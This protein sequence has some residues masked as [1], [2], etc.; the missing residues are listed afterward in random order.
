MNRR[1]VY[2]T[3]FIGSNPAR[4]PYTPKATP[5][6]RPWMLTQC[7]SY[8]CYLPLPILK[9]GGGREDTTRPRDEPSRFAAK[10][11]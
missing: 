4:G 3:P 1:S 8:R 5:R 7:R 11:G 9:P 6:G 2:T 10:S